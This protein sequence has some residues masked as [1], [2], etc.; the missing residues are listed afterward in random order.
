MLDHHFTRLLLS[1][2]RLAS[3]TGRWLLPLTLSLASLV[4]PALQAAQQQW[5]D[6]TVAIVEN[7]VIL[8][9]QI[10]RRIDQVAANLRAKGSTPPP[11]EQL[12]KP[13]LEQLILESLQLQMADRASIRIDDNS[14]NQTIDTIAKQNGMDLDTLQKTLEAEGTPFPVFRERIRREMRISRLRQGIIGSGIQISDREVT[15]FLNSQEGKAQRPTEF[16][17]AHILIALPE[18]ALPETVESARHQADEVAAQLKQGSSFDQ[19]ALTQSNASTALEGGDLGWRREA[20]L[21][22]LFSG[23]VSSM[24]LGEVRGPIRSPSG[25]HFIKLLDKRGEPLK[26]ALQLHVRHILIAPNEIRDPQQSQQLANE[27][28]QRLQRGEAFDELAR[29]YSDDPGSS[30]AGGDLGWSDPERFAPEFQAAIAELPDGVVSKPFRTRFGWHIA[31]VEGRRSTDISHEY[32]LNQA[33]ELLF[34]R[35]FD[36]ELGNWLRKIRDEAYVEFLQ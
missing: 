14:L 25:F 18:N 12:Y 27:I 15:E 32:Q 20:E 6:T 8:A 35:K 33:R 21:P 5:L 29:T 34:R 19:L 36:E 10:N 2:L 7:D 4:S 1:P 26:Q 17:L 30:H 31:R 16:H 23:L 13:V 24:Q 9:S 22:S 28:V 11:R 3:A